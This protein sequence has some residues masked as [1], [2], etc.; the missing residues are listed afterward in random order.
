MCIYDWFEMKLKLSTVARI[1]LRSNH[2]KSANV[3]VEERGGKKEDRDR[4]LT[5]SESNQKL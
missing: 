5:V 3:H 4:E 2:Q 1:L